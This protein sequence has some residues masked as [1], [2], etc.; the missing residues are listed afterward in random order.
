MA[1][2]HSAESLN[3]KKTRKP[4]VLCPATP[5]R[6]E[7]NTEGTCQVEETA[8]VET[9]RKPGVRRRN[10]WWCAYTQAMHTGEGNAAGPRS[11]AHMWREKHVRC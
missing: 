10:T 7:A 1:D 5:C 8:W 3:M 6:R 9:G 4:W 11:P 2:T